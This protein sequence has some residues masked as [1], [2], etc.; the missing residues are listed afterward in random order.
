MSS[1]DDLPQR[2][3][4]H[5]TA[6]AAETAFRAAIDACK[7]F[8]VQREDRNDYGTDVQIEARAGKAMTNIRAHV[9]LKGTKSTTN[10]N[11]SVSVPVARAN[12]NYLLAQAD[13]MYVC[14]HLPSARL[15]VRYAG[16]VYREY[17][18][19]GGDWI[20]QD[21]VTVN[22]SQPFDEQFQR[23]LNV[24]LLESG[25]SSRD[26]RLQWIGTP[27]EKIPALAQSATPIIE[28]PV[29]PVQTREILAEFY[30][31]GN[32][33]IISNSFAQFAAVLNFIPG[34]MD[35][36]YMAEIN[37][38]INGAPFDKDRVRQSVKVLQEAMDRGDVHPGSLLYS[39]GNAWLALGEHEKA[40]GAYRAALTQ[41]DTPELSG[42][43]AQCSKNLGSA[44]EGLCEMDEARALYEQALELDPDLGEAH[45]AL[46]L[47][48][49]RKG[50]APW[51]A[52]EH[53][54]RVIRQG[55]SALQMSAVQGWRIDL[56]FNTGDTEEA[57]R[58]INSL[59]GQANQ[60][61]WVWSWC[62]RH[63]AQFGK[64]SDDAAEKALRFWRAYL[65]EHPRDTC[66]ERERLLC[67]WR[68]RAAGAHTEID[69]DGFKLAVIQLI[70]SGDPDPAYLWDRVGHWAQYDR[71][72]A[73]AESAYRKAYELEPKRYGYCL[74]TALN[75]LSRHREALS[76]LLPQ[77]EEY[78]SDAMSW[79][80]VA[81]ARE[82][83]GDIEGS[84]SA[85]QRALELDADYDLAWFNLGGIYWNARDIGRAT[86][87]WREAVTRFPNHELARKLRQDLPFLFEASHDDQ[88]S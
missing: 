7:L 69:F 59:L 63:V 84:I 58:E 83:V 14:Y 86:E 43:A 47:W 11:G 33:A 29:D 56:L 45:F 31:A 4:A 65:R 41:L 68:L 50:D 22:L 71:D 49:R 5:D 37:L 25:R 81:V 53:L 13:S 32:D 75:F 51:L 82:G 73:K 79:F 60:L 67:L 88:D 38:G 80:Q 87:T 6:E 55:G 16:D 44:L 66:A 27:P 61:D 40:R 62:A 36:A 18:H 46:G 64:T 72:W 42:V 1:F 70:E 10:A 52:L 28:V 76:V 8:L 77:A 23:R 48:L 15:F 19:R 3:S 74:G 35:L 21:T 78:Q 34:A 20:R 17:E 12:L 9:Q 57:F 30:R 2:E 39:L 85:Y 54:D 24:R 26:R